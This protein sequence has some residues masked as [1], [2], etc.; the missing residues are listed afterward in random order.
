MKYTL[1]R[2]FLI[3]FITL[4][5]AV[6]PAHAQTVRN[7]TFFEGT[8][9]PLRVT[10]VFGDEP[11]PTIMVQGGVQ[12]DELSGFFTGQL[13]TKCKLHKGNLIIIPRA[14]EPSILRRSRQINV[15]LNRRF[16]KEY[17]KFYEDRLAK[18][19]RFLLNNADGFI[20][21]HEGSGFYNPKYIN[22][23]R[24]PKRYGQSL[25]IDATVYKNIPL[26]DLCQRA[27]D[28]LNSKIP[29]KSYWFTLF[30]TDTFDKTTHYPEMLKSLT[31]YA[32]VE[33]GIPAMAVEVSKDIMDLEWKVRHQLQATVYLLKE[34]GL[35]VEIPKF[36]F[37]SEGKATGLKILI[38]GSPLSGKSVNLVRG[39]PVSTSGQGDVVS[40]SILEP[41][42]AVYASDRPNLNLLTAPR[43]ALSSFPALQ[44]SLDGDT[45]TTAKVRWSGQQESSPE[46]HGPVFLCWLNGNPHFVPTSGV[47]K[48][49]EGDQ[50]IIEGV[51]GSNRN[52][53]LNLKGFV[54]SATVNSGQDIGYE[55]IIDPSNFMDK[56]KLKSHD[57][58]DRYRIARETP[59]K[60]GAEFYL[61][62]FPRIVKALRLS[63]SHG[64]DMLVD[65]K[66][67]AVREVPADRYVLDEA[68][69]NGK[70]DKIQ[71]F[72]NSL[73]VAWGEY[74]DV[75]SG[76]EVT[77]TLRHS[78]TFEL[79]GGMTFKGLAQMQTSLD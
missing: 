18:A 39:G 35:E 48:V 42:V 1:C 64:D 56:Y 22:K 62:V 75:E 53:I 59:G 33:R 24:N 77:V 6:S 76:K 68:W 10:W 46:P 71:P 28:S 36:S 51:L 57:G 12:G 45:T 16:D 4:F 43:M 74:F 38:N 55:I 66:R 19:I 44:V 31:C 13:L 37:P 58:V 23:M 65:W 78:T 20:H 2:V 34:F 30:N 5:F 29:N 9:Y 72:I 69:S 17:N 7:Y 61:S 70:L 14:N 79:V 3:S 21:L 26:A 40:G 67:D 60:R 15:D 41:A 73:P 49:L 32:L 50:F 63:R 25:I 11:G 27:I 8:Q 52:E 54:A 47:L